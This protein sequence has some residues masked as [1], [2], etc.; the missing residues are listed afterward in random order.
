[1]LLKSWYFVQGF[2]P[3]QS[4]FYGCDGSESHKKSV[5]LGIPKV[6]TREPSGGMSL[7]RTRRDHGEA[8][9]H[10]GSTSEG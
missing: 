5:T 1:M 3:V 6:H 9:D 7:A 10:V 2:N 8:P 4:H